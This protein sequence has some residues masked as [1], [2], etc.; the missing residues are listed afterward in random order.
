MPVCTAGLTLSD[1]SEA[2]Q[3]SDWGDDAAMYS[4]QSD[5]SDWEAQD[6]SDAESI[7]DRDALQVLDPAGADELNVNK[8]GC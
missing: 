5:L 6:S 4:S 2:D 8:R 1:Y 7:Q 3:V